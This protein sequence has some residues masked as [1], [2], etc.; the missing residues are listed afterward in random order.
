MVRSVLHGLGAD[1]TTIH[2][3]NSRKAF[4]FCGLHIWDLRH[5]V[6]GSEHPNPKALLE[7]L[8]T[9]LRSCSTELLLHGEAWP[10]ASGAFLSS[11]AFLKSVNQGA[12][13]KMHLG[14]GALRV[15]QALKM[16]SLC[17]GDLGSLNKM[18]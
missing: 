7:V 16:H 4:S 2:L 14:L 12:S 17:W 3:S 15:E 11:S 1:S 18:G 6:T 9:V 8:V 5:P 10:A 13:L